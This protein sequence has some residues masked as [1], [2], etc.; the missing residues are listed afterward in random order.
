MSRDANVESIIAR[1]FNARSANEEQPAHEAVNDRKFIEALARGVAILEAFGRRS[2]ALSN[3]D[4]H[5]ITGFSKP[6]ITRLTHT[7]VTLK[8]LR[9]VEGGRFVLSP[10]I[11]ALARPFHEAI[12]NKLP[13]DTLAG[14]AASGPW[15]IV[16]AEPSADELIVIA[17]FRGSDASTPNCVVGTRIEPATTSAGHAWI[18]TLGTEARHRALL[19]ADD[20]MRSLELFSNARAQLLDRGYC[21]EAGQWRRD[22]VTLAMPVRADGPRSARIVMCIAPDKRGMRERLVRELVPK[23]RA[24]LPCDV[25]SI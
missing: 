2:G 21:I 9:R 5:E 16:L 17:S 11:A 6:A 25:P 15:C 3:A 10:Q 24:A 4:L 1:H 22:I 13:N 23:I 18:A 12:T 14:I 7:L 20:S 19:T 8:Y